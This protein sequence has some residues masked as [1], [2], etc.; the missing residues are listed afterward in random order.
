MRS[1]LTF[2]YVAVAVGHHTYE[3]HNGG[4]SQSMV[5]RAFIHSATFELIA[6]VAMVRG[7]VSRGPVC[8]RHSDCLMYSHLTSAAAVPDYPPGCARGAASGTSFATRHF[9]QMGAN[10][11]WIGMH[12]ISALP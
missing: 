10:C 5:G 1:G 7:P 11:S 9:G 3:A 2:F 8:G 12:S 4:A 6:S